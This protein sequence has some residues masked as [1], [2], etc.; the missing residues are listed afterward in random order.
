MPMHSDWNLH[1]RGRGASVMEKHEQ[2]RAEAFTP[3]DRG[4]AKNG[5]TRHR[6]PVLP[7]PHTTGGGADARARSSTTPAPPAVSGHPTIGHRVFSGSPACRN[8][9]MAAMLPVRRRTGLPSRQQCS[10]MAAATGGSTGPTCLRVRPNPVMRKAQRNHRNALRTNQPADLAAGFR[11]ASRTWVGPLCPSRF[12]SAQSPPQALLRH[13]S[14]MRQRS[15]DLRPAMPLAHPFEAMVA[16]MR[17]HLVSAYIER[18]RSAEPR[19]VHRRPGEEQHWDKKLRRG[20]LGLPYWQ[21]QRMTTQHSGFSGNAEPPG[22]SSTELR[23]PTEYFKSTLRSWP[24]A[25]T[26]WAPLPAAVRLVGDSLRHPSRQ[27]HPDGTCWEC[28][29]TCRGEAVRASKITV[30]KNSVAWL[31]SKYY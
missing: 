29:T 7:Y 18:H 11:V 16:M 14:A 27:A 8:G 5:R 30:C 20:R 6:R 19:V 2:S 12:R 10:V 9:T 23:R 4:C 13:R 1:E 26:K 22:H 17:P 3:R 31:E 24:A 21:V 15:R 25:A 28:A